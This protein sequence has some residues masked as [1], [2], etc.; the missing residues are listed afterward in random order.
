MR[1][2]T[3]DTTGLVTVMFGAAGTLLNVS[4]RAQNQGKV[5]SLL[6]VYCS[7]RLCFHSVVSLHD[8]FSVVR[9]TGPTIQA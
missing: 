5:R 6:D 3:R 7:I 2:S 9:M 4:K 1:Y 8:G